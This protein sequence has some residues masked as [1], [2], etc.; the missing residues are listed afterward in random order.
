M[1]TRTT[2]LLLLLIC[3]SI[4]IIIQQKQQQSDM[5]YTP[6]T[7]EAP[8]QAEPA[9]APAAP[10]EPAP[11]TSTP[12]THIAVEQPIAPKSRTIKVTNN[13]TQKMLAYTKGFMQYTPDFTLIVNHQAIEP[14][15][16][17]EITINDNSLTI[18]YTYNF[19]NGYKKGSKEIAFTVPAT[20][21]ELD[22]TFSW[23]NDW[24]VIVAGAQPDRI[25]SEVK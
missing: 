7:T 9:P 8:D 12:D 11:P 10:T 20:S 19:M 22:I 24:R 25:I 6:S 17:Q 5:H 21:N 14:G 2:L 18:G 1:N 4:I 15:K 16:Q 3:C 13:I 23:K